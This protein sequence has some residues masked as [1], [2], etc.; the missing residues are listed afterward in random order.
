MRVEGLGWERWG[1][2]MIYLD[3]TRKDDRVETVRWQLVTM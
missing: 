1:G 3:A 2:V